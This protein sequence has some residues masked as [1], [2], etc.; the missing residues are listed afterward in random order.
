MNLRAITTRL[1]SG[2][3]ERTEAFFLRLLGLTYLC[4]FGSLWPQ[5]LGL[6]GSQGIAP[7][8]NLM[9]AMRAQLGSRAFFY[10][11]SLFWINASDNTLTLFCG[12]GC[13]CGMLML[14]G[15]LSRWMAAACF[16]L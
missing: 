1:N 12:L 3:F 13:V 10:T 4:A 14:A 8:A 5:I 6:T 9:T 11:P 16:L 15:L 2:S 7:A